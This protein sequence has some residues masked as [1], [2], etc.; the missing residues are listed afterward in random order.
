MSMILPALCCAFGLGIFRAI[1]VF[2]GAN[3]IYS[4]RT[5]AERIGDT[6]LKFSN[7]QL[8]MYRKKTKNKCFEVLI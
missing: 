2:V 3:L 5:A 8:R 6:S 7:N 4:G 1:L